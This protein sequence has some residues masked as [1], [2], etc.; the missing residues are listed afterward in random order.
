VVAASAVGVLGAFT[1]E[2]E[3]AVSSVWQIFFMHRDQA[4]DSGLMAALFYSIRK[5]L[6][7]FG[8]SL[9]VKQ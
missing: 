3:M 7:A 8:E 5:V 9:Q 6:D 4:R 2:V 1:P